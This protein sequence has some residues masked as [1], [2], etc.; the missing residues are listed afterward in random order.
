M[1][2]RLV[3]FTQQDFAQLI[4][5]SGNEAFLSQW[6]GPFFKYPLTEEQLSAYNSDANDERKSEKLNYKIV[7]AQTNEAVAHLSIGSIDRTNSSARL[8]KVLIGNPSF[9]G[10][11]IGKSM[12][13]SALEICFATLNLHKVSLG[14]YDF[15]LP[16]LKTYESSG[17]SV[18]GVLRDAK[19]AGD[20]YWNLIEMSILEEEWK[21][22]QG[23]AV[24]PH[25]K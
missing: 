25:G 10:K 5:W 1:D 2:I 24:L 22:L 23:I 3:P 17:F 4:E 8:T 11:G 18:D 15:N 14:V 19:K 7:L 9:R 20:S 16:A 6:A 13:E 12:I 21:A